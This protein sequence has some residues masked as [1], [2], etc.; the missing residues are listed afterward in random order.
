VLDEITGAMSLAASG[1]RQ[2]VVDHR[3]ADPGAGLA[4]GALQ[5]SVPPANP[6]YSLRI[7]GDHILVKPGVQEPAV[8]TP[9]FLYLNQADH[10][11]L[12]D[13]GRYE[14]RLGGQGQRWTLRRLPLGNQDYLRRLSRNIA[15]QPYFFYREGV[16]TYSPAQAG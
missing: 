4:P 5:P 16:F 10:R 3:V 7:Q 6:H 9:R 12:V 11:V 1:P 8:Y 13:F 2:R 15:L 14:A